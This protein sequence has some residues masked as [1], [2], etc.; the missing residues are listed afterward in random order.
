[1]FFVV[2]VTQAAPTSFLAPLGV[3]TNNPV[4][5]LHVEGDGTEIPGTGTV[6]TAVCNKS[7]SGPAAACAV[8]GVGGPSGESA[9]VNLVNSIYFA[10]GSASP[11]R[12]VIRNEVPSG[13]IDIETGGYDL[14]ARRIKIQP[15]GFPVVINQFLPTSLGAPLALRNLDNSA[16]VNG[17]SLLFQV[18]TT[19]DSSYTPLTAGY[20]GVIKEQVWSSDFTTHN[21]SLGLYTV[22]DG[23]EREGLH[24][25]SDGVVDAKSGP[26]SV[27]G[28]VGLTR[29][30][31]VSSTTPCT[32][33]FTGGLLTG[34][35]CPQ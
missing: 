29:I 4:A 27:N 6:E 33:T 21:A 20:V 34:T 13:W 9:R 24:I 28:A 7:I 2:K 31:Q 1:M 16:A 12:M 11:P 26:L 23:V 3:G 5:A 30:I 14:T 18:T 32:L 15:N 19:G 25:N 17:M 8:M 35:T 22:R 10:A